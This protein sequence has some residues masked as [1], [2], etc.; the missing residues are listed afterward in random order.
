MLQNWYPCTQLAHDVHISCDCLYV[1]C[2]I[3]IV[4]ISSDT[5]EYV[6]ILTLNKTFLENYIL[7]YSLISHISSFYDAI[8]YDVILLHDTAWHGPA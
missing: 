8:S 2:H 4:D 7:L 1:M 5:D 3:N 6:Y